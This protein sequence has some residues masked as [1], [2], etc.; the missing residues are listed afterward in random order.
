MIASQEGLLPLFLYYSF[1]PFLVDIL[2]YRH[3]FFGN[4]VIH[5]HLWH[6]IT[7]TIHVGAFCRSDDPEMEILQ[8]RL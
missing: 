1:L 2:K 5:K 4:E 8:I 7:A 6:Q 3:I